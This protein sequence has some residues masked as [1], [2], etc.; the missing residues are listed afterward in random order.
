MMTHEPSPPVSW[1][2]IPYRKSAPK[3]EYMHLRILDPILWEWWLLVLPHC[4][5]SRLLQQLIIYKW[6]QILPC[7]TWS[8]QSWNRNL[9]YQT[10]GRNGW[11]FWVSIP[12]TKRS[13]IAFTGHLGNSNPCGMKRF[14][15]P[16]HHVCYQL[17]NMSY[18]HYY[19]YQMLHLFRRLSFLCL[20][21]F[22]ISYMHSSSSRVIIYLSVILEYR[23]YA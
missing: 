10:V 13:H 8:C 17:R 19:Q 5:T 18:F 11:I 1:L 3:E 6:K 23:C 4:A 22:H 21:H 9:K 12:K 7:K 15:F 2:M 16:Q 14:S 20:C